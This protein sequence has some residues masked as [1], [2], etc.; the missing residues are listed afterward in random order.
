MAQTVTG[1]LISLLLADSQWQH[2]SPPVAVY[3][4]SMPAEQRLPFVVVKEDVLAPDWV[5]E[6]IRIETHRV[7]AEVYAQGTGGA[8]TDNPAEVIAGHL[9]RLWNWLD[10]PLSN[11]V[12]IRAELKKDNLI[13]ERERASDKGRVYRADLTWEF[14]FENYG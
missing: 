6:T 7:S 11:T 9:K 2:L 10:L 8:G 13:E 1:T 3:R 4:D 5:T 14:E 12:P